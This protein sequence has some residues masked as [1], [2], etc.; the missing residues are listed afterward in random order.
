MTMFPLLFD[1]MDVNVSSNKSLSSKDNLEER[2][3]SY[4]EEEERSLN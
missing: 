2:V 4:P 3:D 1:I